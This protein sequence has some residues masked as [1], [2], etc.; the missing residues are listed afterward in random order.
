MYGIRCFV[1]RQNDG[2]S[3]KVQ[4]PLFIINCV[5]S[6]SADNSTWPMGCVTSNCTTQDVLDLITIRCHLGDYT[7]L[8]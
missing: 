2:V 7:I 5:H 8:F 6:T 3:S 1:A 4:P